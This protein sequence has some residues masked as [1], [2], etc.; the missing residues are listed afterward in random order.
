MPAAAVVPTAAIIASSVLGLL[1]L[2]VWVYHLSLLASL[3]GSDAAGNGMAQGFAAVAM[4]LLWVLL[5]LLLIIAATT[6]GVPVAAVIAALVLLPAS[7]LAS[8]AAL[9]LL[10]RPGVPP[11]LWPIVTPAVVPPLV[12]AF[13]FWSLVPVLRSA[14]PSGLAGAVVWGAVLILSLA[15]F[16]LTRARNQFDAHQVA[17]EAD[18]AAE[19]ALLPADAPLWD[20]VPF[21][22]GPGNYLFHEQL[23]A[24]M[25]GLARRQGDVETMLDRGDFPLRSL[26]LGALDLEPTPSLCDKAR[27]LLR[28][29]VEPLVLPPGSSTRP[30]AEIAA[31]VAGAADAMDWLVGYDCPC[32]AE[33]LA[34]ETMAKAYTG[35]NWDFYRLA[36]LRDPE[37]LGRVLRDSPPK[38]S[39]LTPRAHLKAWL[40]FADDAAV[41][42]QAIAGARAL[43]HRTADA[44]EMLGDEFGASMV[45]KYLP[46]LDLEPTPALCAAAVRVL[47]DAISKIYR[48]E[49]DDPRSFDE[50]LGRLGAETRIPALTWLA[51]NGCDVDDELSTVQSLAL[52]YQDAPARAPILARLQ[53]LRRKP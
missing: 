9:D 46:V 22:D 34:W 47:H 5:G 27:A 7:G 19:L 38:F 53:Q 48:P 21:V 15:I 33:S 37:R 39:M 23:A 31:E 45:L 3:S 43:D 8:G 16:P 24:R 41:H 2:L 10:I 50:F 1:A 17:L 49:S 4:I 11:F 14:L 12:V 20:L 30:Y 6:G 13:C 52:A 32:D 26:D 28:R 40:G 42:D 18:A 25:R 29:R 36:A 35:S 44:L 51:R